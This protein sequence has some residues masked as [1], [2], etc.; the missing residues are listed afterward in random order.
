VVVSATEPAR[1]IEPIGPSAALEDHDLAGLVGDVAALARI[2]AIE[3]P[4]C[5]PKRADMIF[6]IMAVIYCLFMLTII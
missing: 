2:C 3:S 6:L 1:R 5:P 4:H